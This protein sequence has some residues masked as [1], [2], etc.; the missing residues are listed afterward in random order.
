MRDFSTSGIDFRS[1]TITQAVSGMRQAMAQAVVGD[2]VLGDDPTVTEL[3]NR[4]AELCGKEAGLFV[5]SGTMSNAIA[6]K[7][8][9]QPGDEIITWKMKSSNII[10]VCNNDTPERLMNTYSTL[11]C[12]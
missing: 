3:E 6:L 2:D 8:H 5:A 11:H 9:T 4:V 7:T 12:M 1:D 10:Q